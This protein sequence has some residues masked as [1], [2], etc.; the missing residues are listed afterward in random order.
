MPTTPK[1]ENQ[2]TR[3]TTD[4]KDKPPRDTGQKPAPNPK[5]TSILPDTSTRK[6]VEAI[7]PNLK[8]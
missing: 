6:E 1:P 4:P 5:A 3:P 2:P 8:R 7:R